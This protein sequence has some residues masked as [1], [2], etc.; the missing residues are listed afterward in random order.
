MASDVEMCERHELKG[1][2]GGDDVDEID[3]Q[4]MMD[5][6]LRE[7]EVQN[8]DQASEFLSLF[9]KRHG[10]NK[11][12][13]YRD[14][15]VGERWNQSLNILKDRIERSKEKNIDMIKDVM[16]TFSPTYENNGILYLRLKTEQLQAGRSDPV[17]GADVRMEYLEGLEKRHLMGLVR[18]EKRQDGTVVMTVRVGKRGDRPDVMKVN[19]GAVW[20]G[21]NFLRLRRAIKE[22]YEAHPQ[23]KGVKELRDVLMNNGANEISNPVVS[24]RLN[25]WLS[26]PTTSPSQ[27][28]ALASTLKRRVSIIRGPPGTGKSTTIAELVGLHVSAYRDLKEP[29]AIMV[30]TPTNNTAQDNLRKEADLRM[31]LGATGDEA[32]D[33]IRVSWVVSRSYSARARNDTREL[34]VGYQATHL[35]EED[36]SRNLGWDR[37]REWQIKLDKNKSLS[38]EEEKNYKM[39]HK[40]AVKE[41]IKRAEVIV[42][43]TC[44]AGLSI[45]KEKR[46]GLIVIDEAGLVEEML[47]TAAVALGP[48][49]LVLV[50]DEHQLKAQQVTGEGKRMRVEPFF[51]RVLKDLKYA[52]TLVEHWRMC[53]ACITP[54]NRQYYNNSLVVADSVETARTTDVKAWNMFVDHTKPLDWIDVKGTEEKETG[55]GYSTLNK[56]EAMVC[57]EFVKWTLETTQNQLA[58]DDIAI[59]TGYA[60]QVDCISAVLLEAGLKDVTVGTTDRSLARG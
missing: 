46:F 60:A 45:L 22:T 49:Q 9:E 40:Q 4:A 50:G 56:L 6:V 55:S 26:R 33:S 12:V 52:E 28:Q 59:I 47:A 27:K 53:R 14:R 39:L 15:R 1:V 17:K 36:G 38:I 24:L 57:V 18:D 41:V 48:D 42:G 32:A 51:H 31:A 30:L 3:E 34:T 8:A 29:R 44:Q 13:A 2:L 25:E 11:H 20:Q 21:A 7:M 10:T 16:I 5:K 19:V 58:T 23:R 54:V 35:R 37:L 43:T